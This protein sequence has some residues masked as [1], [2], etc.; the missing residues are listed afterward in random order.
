MPVPHIA[1]T[2]KS[3]P[4]DTF[5][6]QSVRRGVFWHLISRRLPEPVLEQLCWAGGEAATGCTH[7]T[8]DEDRALD[9]TPARDRRK[10][11]GERREESGER[12]A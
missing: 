7:H 5:A 3:N 4:E 10:S 6:I 12:R 8:P 1:Q 9:T 2:T 11:R